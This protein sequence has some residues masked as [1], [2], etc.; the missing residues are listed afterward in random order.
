[1]KQAD[2][3]IIGGGI[4]GIQAAIQLGRYKHDIIV[5]DS[6]QGRSSIAKAYHNILGM[7]RRGK[8]QTIKDAWQTAR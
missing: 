7:A 6:A 4:A 5:I 3:I 8:R 2:C 1:M